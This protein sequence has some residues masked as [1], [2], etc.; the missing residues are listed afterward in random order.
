M[1]H[2]S[3]NFWATCIVRDTEN[4]NFLLASCCNVEVV[5]GADGVFLPG[6]VSILDILNS[7]QMQELK[8]SCTSSD[9]LKSLFNVAGKGLLDSH[10]KVPT[11]LKKFAA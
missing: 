8:K 5:N 1:C 4:H 6:L 10:L 3:Y 11:V 7:D 9:F 2:A